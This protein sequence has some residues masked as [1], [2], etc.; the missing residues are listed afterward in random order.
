MSD[1]GIYT[2]GWICAIPA[3]YVAAQ[4]F[5]DEE[6][7]G[8]AY[9]P[10]P[11]RNDYAL[12]K[13]G[14][15]NVVIA[16]LP[17][18]EYGNVSA[19]RVAEEMRFG[20]PNIRIGLMVGI[21]G[22]VPTRHDIRLGDVVV[23]TPSNGLGGVLQYDFGMTTQG[24]GF[25]RTSFLDQPPTALRTAVTGIQ[26]Q[27][28]R[29]GHC[30]E[31]AVNGVLVRNRR[32]RSRYKR[33]IPSSDRLYRSEHTGDDPAYLIQREERGDEDDDPMIHYGLIAS[34]SQ[35]MKD[36]LLRDELAN[37]FDVLCFEMEAAGLMNNFPCL[38]IRGIC[39]YCDSHESKEWQGYAAM[40]AAAYAK[41]L[42]SRMTPYQVEAEK[43]LSE[44]QTTGQ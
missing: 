24:K 21:G 33:P 5:L 44:I 3:E 40:I 39:N 13:M 2:V 1:P 9:L 32:L 8:P 43:K 7:D 10:P 22:G 12:G 42:L 28:E 34:G 36:A 25:Q 15:H 4:E 18:G 6:H 19:A 35:L 26:A 29:K 16:T 38:I 41:D 17:M 37:E 27:Y 23:S 11:V 30:L 31:D 14:K 20:F